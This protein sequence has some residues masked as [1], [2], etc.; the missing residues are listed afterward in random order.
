MTRRLNKSDRGGLISR[1]AAGRIQRVVQRVEGGDRN[2]PPLPLRTAYGDDAA[3]AVRIGKVSADWAVGECAT[4]DIWE[5]FGSGCTTPDE[6]DPAESI[7]D[8]LN[9]SFNVASGSWVAITQTQSG[10]WVLVE[11][12]NEE[13]CQKTIGGEDVTKW[14]GW[15]GDSTQVLGHDSSGCLQWID[16]TECDSGSGS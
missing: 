15:D 1:E 8:V 16:V 10:V 3:A 4:V 11:T 5:T 6:N 9:L 13:E 2:I 7:E 12:G 14:P